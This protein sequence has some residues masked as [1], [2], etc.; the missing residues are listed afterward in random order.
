MQC[1]NV[2]DAVL[3]LVHSS[4]HKAGIVPVTILHVSPIWALG[5]ARQVLDHFDVGVEVFTL[6]RPRKGL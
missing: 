2:D 5:E 4:S 1:V 3:M 6:W